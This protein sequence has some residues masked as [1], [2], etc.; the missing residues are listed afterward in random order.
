MT[1]KHAP[2][3][4]TLRMQPNLKALWEAQRVELAEQPDA[5]GVRGHFVKHLFR[6][7]ECL[8]RD[9]PDDSMLFSAADAVLTQYAPLIER[10]FA[11]RGA[12]ADWSKRGTLA[13]TLAATLKADEHV[14]QHVAMIVE[15][16]VEQMVERSG[17]A[18]SYIPQPQ[19]KINVLHSINFALDHIEHLRG[20]VEY[21]AYASDTRSLYCQKRVLCAVFAA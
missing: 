19:K 16:N 17:E 4:T 3:R 15:G 14:Q 10:R 20:T 21:K 7:A 12:K 18:G 13:L 6:A 11:D 2:K 1:A 8:G 5:I 9:D